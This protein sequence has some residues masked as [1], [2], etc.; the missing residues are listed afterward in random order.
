MGI[1]ELVIDRARKEGFEIGRKE[2]LKEGLK[3]YN[4]GVIKKLLAC[5]KCTIAEIASYVNV[6][7]A[8]VISVQKSLG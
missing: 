2:G 7:E 3:E 1:I 6:T 5:N 4:Q 8:F